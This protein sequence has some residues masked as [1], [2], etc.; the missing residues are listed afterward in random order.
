VKYSNFIFFNLLL[1]LNCSDRSIEQ[2]NR[3]LALGDYQRAVHLFSSAVD[4]NPN[5]FDARLGLGKAL[6]QQLSSGSQNDELWNGCIINL[7]AARTLNT[8]ADVEKLLSAAWNQRS[9]FRL[10]LKDTTGAIHS[11]LKSIEYDKTNIKSLNL[12]GILYF[13]RNEF[14]KAL[15]MFSLV[16]HFDSLSPTGD[17][18]KGMIY[19]SGGDCKSARSAWKSALGKSPLSSDLLYWIALSD[20][21]C[22]E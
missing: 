12:A 6:L 18:N 13:N 17:F 15:S 16:T 3:N 5:S 14:K 7:E 21:T 11:L 4:R 20:S 9:A 2:G 19:W 8:S 1:F 22:P 10:E